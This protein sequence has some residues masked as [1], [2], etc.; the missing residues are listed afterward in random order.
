MD[1]HFHFL[2]FDI[3]GTLI[4]SAGAGKRAMERSFETVYGIQNG[5]R[6]IQMMGRTDPSILD[7]AIQLF[8]L[9][10]SQSKKDRFRDLYFKLLAEEIDIDRPG[11]KI[12]AGVYSLLKRLEQRKDTL[13]GLLTGNWRRSGLIKLRHFG[14]DT[15]FKTGAFADDSPIRNDLPNIAITRAEKLIGKSVSKE[16]VFI[17]GDT[18]LDIQCARPSGVKTVAVATG[19]HTMDQLTDEQ[20]DFCFNDFGDNESFIRMIFQNHKI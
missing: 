13:I 8:H 20:P 18:P 14:I 1:N 4:R 15:F 11:K 16:H 10:E 12:C 3:D 9:D 19:V 7:E 17:I 2:L 5:L 6:D